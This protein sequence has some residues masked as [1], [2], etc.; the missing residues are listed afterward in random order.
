[1]KK[2]NKRKSVKIEEKD[3]VL[4]IAVT[5]V[6]A[7]LIV[8]AII[9]VVRLMN[10]KADTEAGI[11]RL[12]QM[13]KTDVSEVDRQIQELEKAE[14]EADEEWASR[15]AS[16][17]FANAFVI[18]D[19]VTQGLYEY[20]VLNQENVQA[21]RGAGVCDSEVNKIEEHL[22]KAIEV[23]PQVLFLAYGMNDIEASRGDVDLF[24]EKYKSVLDRLREALPDTRIYVNSILPVQQFVIDNNEWYGNITEF[25]EELEKL[26]EEE[27]VI[28]IDNTDLVKEEYYSEDGIHMAPD[29]YTEWVDHMAEVAK[30]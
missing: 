19:S 11:Q 9:V 22:T 5:V 27:D 30:L 16:E 26:C 6:I 2:E 20:G 18:G 23:Q 10:P 14:Q 17:K 4:R 15:P 21:D 1:M 12:H 28:F 13:E 29:Y 24:I 25:N 3:H 8:G 7:L